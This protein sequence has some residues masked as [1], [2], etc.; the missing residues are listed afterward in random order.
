MFIAPFSEEVYEYVG[1]RLNCTIP[2][3]VACV[4]YLKIHINRECKWTDL[5]EY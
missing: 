4:F 2:K 1:Y 5:K 3:P